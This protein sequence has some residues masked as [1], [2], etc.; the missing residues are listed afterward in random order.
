M[1]TTDRQR[2]AI[3]EAEG[4]YLLERVAKALG[5]RAPREMTVVLIKKIV[6]ECR[7]DYSSKRMPSCGEKR[8]PRTP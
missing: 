8:T 2:Q 1:Q 3:I 4:S 7:F 6:F 5:A